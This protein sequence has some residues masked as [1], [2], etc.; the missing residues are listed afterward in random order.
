MP[1]TSQFLKS[2]FQKVLKA[3]FKFKLTWL[4]DDIVDLL[5][6]IDI[7]HVF[8]DD[9][10]RTC[11]SSDPV[12]H[13]YEPFLDAYDPDVKQSRGVFYTPDAIV[14]FMI[15]TVHSALLT[16]LAL[17]LGLADD[18]TW[19]EYASQRQI[20]LPPKTCPDD[21]VV[22]ILDPAAGTGTFLKHAILTI[23]ETLTTHWRDSGLSY[24]QT[25]RSWNDYVTTQLVRRINGLEVMAAPYAICHLK[26]A[27]TLRQTGFQGPLPTLN[28]R[29]SNS[30][31]KADTKEQHSLFDSM[32]T[33]EATAA[34][35][36][37]SGRRRI[38]VVIG[39]PPYS[40]HSANLFVDS[41][42]LVDR[43]RFIA[44]KRIKE[45]GALQ[46]ERNLQDDYVKFVSLCQSILSKSVAGIWCFVTSH[47][48]IDGPTLSGLRF[49][50][51]EDFSQLH[52][53]NAHGNVNRGEVTPDGD[54]DEN[55]F[56]IKD[57]GIAISC[58]VRLRKSHQDTCTCF[59]SD[60]W[61]SKEVKLAHLASNTVY[62]VHWSR[63][64]PRKPNYYLNQ[65]VSRVGDEYAGYWPIDRITRR[66]SNG[67]VTA[68][69]G[70]VIDFDKKTLMQRMTGFATRRGSA[71]AVC[72][73]FNVSLKKG[74]DAASARYALRASVKAGENWVFKCLYRP[75][76]IMELY[77]HRAVIQTMSSM[78]WHMN[79][80]ANAA[81]LVPRTVKGGPFHHVMVTTFMS[82]AICL[83][84]KTSVN[85][86]C[87]PL[88]LY[89]SAKQR[90]LRKRGLDSSGLTVKLV[91]S[92]SVNLSEEF[93]NAIYTHMDAKTRIV[94]RQIFFYLAAVLHSKGYQER[95]AAQI[96]KDFPRIPLPRASRLVRDLAIVGEQLT[97]CYD[98][99]IATV[100]V[101]TVRLV[102]EGTGEVLQATF[103]EEE[104]NVW[105]NDTQFLTPI[106]SAEWDFKVGDYRAIERWLVGGR[107]ITR[108]GRKLSK[109]DVRQ[110]CRIVASITQ[111]RKLTAKVDELVC[112]NG[113]WPGAFVT[114]VSG[115]SD[116]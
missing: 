42:R 80:G 4:L 108:K 106:T 58:G 48:F 3:T 89:D 15:G 1:T 65:I 112:D 30:L 100:D 94:S 107:A 56:P 64:T 113:G 69:D 29:L 32:I 105:I 2:F 95:Y 66:Y 61:G 67:L 111:L 97:R 21:P 85:G 73:A 88:W 46:F 9:Y 8:G 18:T 87:F 53:L 74:W 6:R 104:G 102:G 101:A 76:E 78:S 25:R 41:K 31:R 59:Y 17:P 91:K 12:I 63:T 72:G 82:E 11:D 75:F 51:M 84:T 93:L 96:G 24:A 26:L 38:S 49:A 14:S 57:T 27:L 10:K 16:K 19:G 7:D 92:R 23:H 34:N 54:K 77:Y 99:R 83:S 55:L 22:S 109:R 37:K 35:A 28:V 60:L 71:E 47:G 33:K 115:L 5:D 20:S 52:V 68:R 13:F 114:N 81:I 39:N 43:Y 116:E 98:L 45:K 44:E 79:A 62:T 36:L 86:N 70:L 50:L 103:N 110:V 90:V 40:G